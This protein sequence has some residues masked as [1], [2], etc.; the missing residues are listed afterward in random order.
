[1]KCDLLVIGGGSGGVRA[2][3]LAAASGARVVLA[4]KSALGGTCVNVGCVP[5]KLF[6]FASSFGEE[7]ECAAAFGWQN[8]APGDFNWDILRENKDRE[9]LRLNA[10]YAELL[11]KA[12]VEVVPKAA[13][14]L[15]G[16]R[17]DIGGA[18]VEAEKILIACGAVPARPPLPGAEHGVLS[19][20]MFYLPKLPR[21]AA[22]IGGGYIALEFAGILSGLGVETTI[23]HRAEL[24]LR[25][26]DDDLRA[27]LAAETAKRGIAVRAGIAPAAIENKNGARRV[28]FADGS[29]L[30]ADLVLLAT[31]RKPAFSGL[32][33][34][35]AEIVPNAR[36]FLETDEDYQIKNRPGIYAIGDVLQ[37][38]ALTPVATA[39]AGVFIARVFGGDKTAAVDYAHLPTAV[40]S[41]PQLATAGMSESA[42]A[43]AGIK[44]KI[45]K[46]EFRAMKRGFAGKEWQT[47]MKLVVREEDGRVLGAHLIGEDAGEIIQGFA[48]ALRCGASK[49]DFDSTVGVH[50]TT[51][52]EFVTMRG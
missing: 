33:L 36:G 30:E 29:A 34:E 35:A 44:T 40:F 25:G 20:D 16:Q 3:R 24:P 2:A 42:A 7:T 4:E 11:N 6:V 52:E 47:L 38:P 19:D 48:V 26:F 28:V 17:A 51:A 39:E 18:E 37:T 50:P 12:G 21:R 13:R 45:Y 5:K 32:G 22:V 41:R 9:I 15:G 14:L 10:V 8:A 23:C 43:V 46:S 27:H 49:N 1:M 31:G